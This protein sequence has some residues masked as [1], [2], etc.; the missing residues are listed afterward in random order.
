[1]FDRRRNEG[2]PLVGGRRMT[3]PESID[4]SSE[5]RH[6]A[7]DVRADDSERAAKLL[8]VAAKNRV[9]NISVI[10]RNLRSIIGIMF[11]MMVIAIIVSVGAV[12]AASEAHDAV[13]AAERN[14]KVIE[15]N[16]AEL[17]RAE[18]TSCRR[19]QMQR[20]RGN[21]SNARQY[22]IL[23]GADSRRGERSEL[24]ETAIRS[25]VYSPPVDCTDAVGGRLI[26]PPREIPYER[27]GPEYALKVLGAAVDPVQPQPLPRCYIKAK[28]C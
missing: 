22:L 2:E 28:F 9:D 18:V 20:E 7:A 4:T 10:V 27:L 19:A 23:L 5:D 3:D 25:A 24:F 17:R 1:M 15:R 12:I 14:V 26:D 21:V 11:L 6:D 16:E 13:D 8:A